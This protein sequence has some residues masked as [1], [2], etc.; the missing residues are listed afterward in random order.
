MDRIGTLGVAIG[1]LSLVPATSKAQAVAFMPGI[2]S[3]PNGAMMSATP[4]VSADRRYVRLTVNPQFTVLQG[5]DSYSVPGAVTGGGQTGIGGIGGLGGAGGGIGG[6]V[7]FA[8][9]NGPISGDSSAMS[10]GEFA[11]DPQGFVDQS[12]Q[13]RPDVEAST[14]FEDQ[15]WVEAPPRAEVSPQRHQSAPKATL[16]KRRGRPARAERS[17]ATTKRSKSAAKATRD[18]G[19][20]VTP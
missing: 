6:G 10:S 7:G 11:A 18:N 2:G 8:G 20:S 9:M 1:L 15:R 5:F 4:V 3:F 16:K 12:P 19:A 13:R 17:T 14:D